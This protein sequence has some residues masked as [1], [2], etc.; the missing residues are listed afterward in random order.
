MA[1][2]AK[3]GFDDNAAFRHKDLF[4]ERD[5]SQEDPRSDPLRSS[6]LTPWWQATHPVAAWALLHCSRLARKID[7][8]NNCSL[9]WLQ[10]EMTTRTCLGWRWP[11]WQ[12]P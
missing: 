6:V 9:A 1:A 2:D 11:G 10:R 5:A 8:C 3:L 7:V 12:H 4:A